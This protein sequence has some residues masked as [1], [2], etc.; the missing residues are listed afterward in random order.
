M[1]FI[2]VILSV[3]LISRLTH[4]AITGYLQKLDMQINVIRSDLA[5]S[6]KW[7]CKFMWFDLIAARTLSNFMYVCPIGHI[8]IYIYIYVCVCVLL[9]NV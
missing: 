4:A 6:K 1:F 2:Y 9:C 3:D 8:Y 5:T 7:T